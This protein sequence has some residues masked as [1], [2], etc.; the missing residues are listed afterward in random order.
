MV[1]KTLCLAMEAILG[2]C[3]GN[4][5]E[6]STNYRVDTACGKCGTI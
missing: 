4:G 5:V 3:L 2:Y 1:N 6:V